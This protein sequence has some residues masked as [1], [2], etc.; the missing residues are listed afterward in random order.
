MKVLID[1]NIFLD[2]AF[3]REELFDGSYKVFQRIEKGQIEAYMT[4]N[5]FTDIYYLMKKQ[6]KDT[7]KVYEYLGYL[8]DLVGI[9][10]I[11]EQDIIESF[12]WKAD[13]FE[14]SIVYVACKNYGCD[15]II[16]RN[17][18]DF[19]IYPIEVKTPEKFIQEADR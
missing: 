6:I 7:A 14:D 10:P 2:V 11:T 17:V 16:T 19:K 3:K 5:A 15:M 1:T 12:A 18:K 4:A 13:D 9:L 8:L